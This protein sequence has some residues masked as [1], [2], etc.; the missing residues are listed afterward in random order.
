MTTHD[1]RSTA[2]K[3][4][5]DDYR[6][7]LGLR[8]IVDMLRDP[9]AI[10][11]VSFENREA[12]SLDDVIVGLTDRVRYVQAKYTVEE[13]VW[14][15]DDLLERES[16]RSKSLL[17]KWADGWRK[18]KGLGAAYE[19]VV[20]TRR[21]PD[22]ELAKLFA[23]EQFAPEL[24]DAPEFE[25]A[26]DRIFEH[27][28][29]VSI[30]GAD[31]RQFLSELRFEF[32]EV[33]VEAVLNET[34]RDFLSLGGTED[35][36][37]HLLVTLRTWVRYR[38]PEPDGRV[39]V[40][41]ARVAAKLWD[42]QAHALP[43]SFQTDSQVYV[44][45]KVMRQGIEVA[46]ESGPVVLLEG[47]PGSGKSS[48]LAWLAAAPPQGTRHVFLHHCF[49]GL[50]DDTAVARLDPAASS[51]GLL[52]QIVREAR[53]DLNQP[54]NP[55]PETLREWLTE[56][57]DKAHACGEHVLLIL[58]GLDHMIREHELEDARTFLNWLPTP[59]PPGLKVVLGTQP[60]QN[61]LP[62][63]LAKAGVQR[64]DM[65]GFDEDAVRSYLQAY[66]GEV[67]DSEVVD[68]ALE[69]SEGN[70]LYLR[71]LV[72]S[73]E[74]QRLTRE[75]ME[76]L[77][78]Y[79][80]NIEAYYAAL[81]ERPNSGPADDHSAA[82]EAQGVI[83]LLG[84]ANFPLPEAD[85]VFLTGPL[86]LNPARLIAALRN[87]QH[88]LNQESRRNGELRLYHESL[89]RFVRERADATAW[90]TPALGALLDWLRERAD[91]ETRWSATWELQLYKGDATPLLQGVTRD[92][93]LAALTAHR[94]HRRILDLMHLALRTAAD[95]HDVR[96]LLRVGWLR[97][98]VAEVTGDGDLKALTN[99]LR[100]QL[101]LGNLPAVER[102][103]DSPNRY[104]REGRL[105]LAHAA[106]QLGHW[107]LAE[108]IAREVLEGHTDDATYAAAA[109][110]D[111]SPETLYAHY[112]ER[113]A[114]GNS[115]RYTHEDSELTWRRAFQRYLDGLVRAERGM[116][117]DQL[118]SLAAQ[119]V[120]DAAAVGN[121]IT[122]LYVRQGDL[123]RCCAAIATLPATPYMRAV[124]LFGGSPPTVASEEV[125]VPPRGIRKPNFFDDGGWREGHGE[126]LWR[127][128]TWSAGG[129]DDE[130]RREADLLRRRGTHGR[131][132]AHLVE[133]GIQVW[134]SLR[135]D[136]VLDLAAIG[137]EL[138]GIGVPVN[139]NDADYYAWKSGM[140]GWLELL[141]Q[142]L[143]LLSA[144]GRTVLLQ[145]RDVRALAGALGLARLL[146][147]LET[148]D[149][150]RL[151]EV[152]ET[153]EWLKDSLSGRLEPFL[154]R[155]D[156]L[157][158]AAG[159]A[160]AAGEGAVA[161]QL[162]ARANENLLGHGYHKDMVL[163]QI[164]D[165]VQAADY[166]GGDEGLLT[167]APLIEVIGEVTDGDEMRQL[168]GELAE[169]LLQSRSTAFVGLYEKFIAEG[170]TVRSERAAGQFLASCAP[171]DQAAWALA[172]SLVEDG[173]EG[174]RIYLGRA[175]EHARQVGSEDATARED[176]YRTWLEVDCPIASREGHTPEHPRATPPTSSEP[177][178]SAEELLERWADGHIDWDAPDRITL[179][180]QAW[181]DGREAPGRTTVQLVSDRLL[182]SD[183]TW[184][185]AS[186]YDA[187]YRLLRH[188]GE[189]ERAFRALVAAQSAARGWSSYLTSR[190]E[191]DARVDLVLTHYRQR[192]EEFL[193]ASAVDSATS[194]GT[195][196][197]VPRI[198]AALMGGGRRGLATAIVR[199]FVTFGHSLMGDLNLG[200]PLWASSSSEG[201]EAIDLV[202]P[203]LGHL[204]P[205]A[206]VR[207]ARALAE[208]APLD[209]RVLER[210]VSWL[211]RERPE[212]RQLAALLA[213]S[214][215]SY[216]QPVRVELLLPRVRATLTDAGLAIRLMFHEL[217]Q[218]CERPDLTLLPITSE[219]HVAEPVP[220][221][222]WFDRLLRSW[223][224]LEDV[225]SRIV[226]YAPDVR[227]R[228][229]AEATDLGLS[230]TLA[231]EANTVMVRHQDRSEKHQ[232]FVQPQARDLLEAAY[233]RTLVGLN[234][235]GVL[236]LPLAMSFAVKEFPVD[237]SLA[238]LRPKARPDWLPRPEPHSTLMIWPA[239]ASAAVA[240]Q[241]TPPSTGIPV[242]LALCCHQVQPDGRVAWRHIS[243]A[244]AY[245]TISTVP[246]AEEVW[247]V[248]SRPFVMSERSTT[249]VLDFPD[250][251][252]SRSDAT[253]VQV[254]GLLVRPLVGRLLFL[255][256]GWTPLAGFSETY[257]PLL[258]KDILG[259]LVPTGEPLSYAA[260]EAPEVEVVQGMWWQDGMLSGMYVNEAR[261]L[262]QTG[263]CLQ[264]EPTFL[265]QQLA[266]SGWSLGWV[267]QSRTSIRRGYSDEE[268]VAELLTLQGVSPILRPY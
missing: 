148:V 2:S 234:V 150:Q 90:K 50:D 251:F 23:G 166:P 243:L 73:L 180:L 256:G 30:E 87:V 111:V 109:L 15:L 173:V 250:A 216:E 7:F 38:R 68:T 103:V 186:P 129:R 259:P 112:R 141:G 48:L 260:A 257:V 184:Q 83:A 1:R 170:R 165:A 120:E 175:S 47:P 122:R 60:V 252:R 239:A 56:V 70:P 138:A 242:P 3:N 33:D 151:R 78:L 222:A 94:P 37:D 42:S 182:A 268:E 97:A 25:G 193:T 93:S 163:Y 258:E 135:D 128:V 172:L 199:D 52:S 171:D 82:A 123:D 101:R 65:S 152:P 162:L 248:L 86:H 71:Y 106:V 26:R 118:T 107:E 12:G 119:D 85:L 72:A 147:W 265:A 8:Y 59:A 108:R 160:A 66:T 16:A 22:P 4:L 262:N 203:R 18:V 217:C 218:D 167:V 19:A 139:P 161:E 142:V 45:N 164:M 254:E 153:L 155:A 140:D 176:A 183:P 13:N 202:M 178:L 145:E 204:L 236:R 46:F 105:E 75:A 79:G 247:S 227:D 134:A 219:V 27:L 132:L 32:G 210:L 226:E 249:R 168:P 266:H 235:Q 240:E 245:R 96:T 110:V 113:L 229:Y 192:L 207:T 58:D 224:G 206:R 133:F 157:S 237:S 213:L 144:S 221:L 214:L 194:Y 146:P 62:G 169:H 98:Y 267:S 187:L 127:A 233:Q 89:R 77:P 137:D 264:A 200:P 81:W 253:E 63:P 35:G 223:P 189:H 126:L 88:L 220:S 228:L 104:S 212:T 261:A 190:P 225:I 209:N 156:L 64:L 185:R 49:L 36:W 116:D 95:A 100:I 40:G 80:G 263:F 61:L 74:G 205:E 130:L 92:W 246:T 154:T 34:R 14:T 44:L 215:I 238:R 99:T 5:G 11:W 241:L 69:R 136:S 54:E 231:R 91:E 76:Q 159:F 117:L 195:V 20:K 198:V 121:A 21:R 115:I 84:W 131:F 124:A 149:V 208:L 102:A 43:Q 51:F 10:L 57:A 114:V 179:T 255:G 232:T 17:Q 24:L 31:A 177:P 158:R 196:L 41:D 143:E 125:L 9:G 197:L 28:A 53:A 67:L 244:F 211:E 6:D 174:A 188:Y 181:I 230:E 191:S 55:K 39:R 29:H 201:F